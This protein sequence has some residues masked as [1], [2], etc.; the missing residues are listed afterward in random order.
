MNY[1]VSLPF[2]SEIYPVVDVDKVEVTPIGAWVMTRGS[3]E[4]STIVAIVPPGAFVHL[5][6]DGEPVEREDA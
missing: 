4:N 3:D 5:L 6:P 2:K 1:C